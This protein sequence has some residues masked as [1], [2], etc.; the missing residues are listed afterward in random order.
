MKVQRG[1]LTG[2]KGNN[3]NIRIKRYVAK[4]T[5]NPAIAHGVS[6][7]IGSIEVGQARRSRAVV[8]GFFWR[9]AGYDHQGRHDRRARHG[10]SKRFDPDAAAG[11]LPA[12]VWRVRQGAH[13]HRASRS[14]R[15]RRRRAACAT[16]S[17]C[18]KSLWRSKT[19]AVGS[20]K[21]RSSTMMRRRHSRRSR[22]ICG[23][24]G[25]RAAR[26]RT[27]KSAAAGAAVFF[28]LMRSFNNHPHPEEP[29]KMASRRATT[30]ATCPSFE[31][32]ASPAPQDEGRVQ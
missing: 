32:R 19:C 4:Y 11:A 31:T 23:H 12:D 29:S 8:A 10:R 7:H 2:D 22:D 17:A 24:R 15:R 14:C 21:S 27:G 25:R 20:A 28:V 16:S 30:C 9:E 26:L 18:R 6:K 13:Q 5:I 3:D 1:P